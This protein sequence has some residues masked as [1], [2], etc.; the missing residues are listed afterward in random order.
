[1]RRLT[2]ELRGSSCRC[3]LARPRRPHG[4]L[5]GHV[6]L[7]EQF[8]GADHRL[9]VESRRVAPSIKASAMAIMVMPW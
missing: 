2:I 8:G 3:R 4:D 9:G 6:F 7:E 5:P 1:M